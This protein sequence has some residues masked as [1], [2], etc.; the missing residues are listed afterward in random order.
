[1]AGVFTFVFSAWT[2]LSG[3]A[4]DVFEGVLEAMKAWL[5]YAA[6]WLCKLATSPLLW[7]I[8][9]IPD[10]LTNSINWNAV[11]KWLGFVNAWV[12]LDWIATAMAAYI[13]FLIVFV[14]VKVVLYLF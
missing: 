6:V 14:V 1:M 11:N 13:T 2:L 9:K 3:L 12:P 8:G 4:R 5:G 10:F 7:V